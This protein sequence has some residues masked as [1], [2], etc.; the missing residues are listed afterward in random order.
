[1]TRTRR[2]AAPLAIVILLA[3][4]LPAGAVAAVPSRPAARPLTLAAS[5]GSVPALAAPRPLRGPGVAERYRALPRAASPVTTGGRPESGSELGRAWQALRKA[6]RGGSGQSV[7][8]A[9]MRL[10]TSLK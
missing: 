6:R 7:R 8:S 10:A 1:M 2:L 9:R 5:P 3:I 4:V